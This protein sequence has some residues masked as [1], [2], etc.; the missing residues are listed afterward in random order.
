MDCTLYGVCTSCLP[1]FSL[2]GDQQGQTNP[3]AEKLVTCM[4]TA[5]ATP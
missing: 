4:N 2:C 1:P 5:C 3:L